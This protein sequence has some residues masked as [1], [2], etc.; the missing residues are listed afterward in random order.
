MHRR[1]FI[2]GVS[3]A[4]LGILGGCSA[5]VGTVA[6]PDVSSDAL[7]AGGWERADRSEETVFSES[8]GPVEVAGKAVTL[9][10]RNAELAAAVAED[11]G[12]RVNATLGV[13]TA[14]HIN[15]D[16]PLNDLPGN[17]GRAEVL[18]KTTA[19]ARSQF[20]RR[21]RGRG[22]TNITETG[23]ET[24]TT[25]TGREPAMATFQGDYRVGDIEYETGGDTVTI[26]AGGI[27]VAG[28]LAVW[29]EGDDVVVAGGAYPAQ[30]YTKTATREL[31][32][33]I[34]I[35]IDIDLGLTPADYR[36]NVRQLMATTQ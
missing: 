2:G 28:D 8:Y 17:V 10:Y 18:D 13:F 30:N 1:S 34:T 24:L 25:A 33:A 11:T 12:G 32:D 3:A 22:V 9:T 16:P 15:F 14:S 6:P 23:V 36:A 27:A 7:D 21:M 26:D 4:G 19:Q 20:R 29:N 31:S 35:T 5:A